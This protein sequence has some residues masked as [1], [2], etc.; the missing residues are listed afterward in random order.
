VPDSAT[1]TL[2]GTYTVKGKKVEF[3]ASGGYQMGYSAGTQSIVTGTIDFSQSPP[4]LS[5]VQRTS[6]AMGAN[7]NDT[8]FGMTNGSSY[9]S[10]VTLQKRRR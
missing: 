2:R 10:V 4:V 5:M 8:Q 3:R 6:S 9:R 1:G 7:V